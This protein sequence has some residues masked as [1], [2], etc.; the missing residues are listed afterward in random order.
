MN[1][2]INLF[3][4]ASLARASFT[5]MAA[6]PAPSILPPP[7]QVAAE[8]PADGSGIYR[9]SLGQAIN[10]AALIVLV[11]VKQGK[12][13][14]AVA[15]PTHFAPTWAEADVSGLTF[16]PSGFKGVLKVGFW[17][18]FS[19]YTNAAET[20]DGKPNPKFIAA[21]EAKPKQFVTITLDLAQTGR[22]GK[23]TW[24]GVWEGPS[25]FNNM[26]VANGGEI[27][28]LWQSARPDSS[29]VDR[30]EADLHMVCALVDSPMP[31][32]GNGNL[33]ATSPAVWLRLGL[34]RGKS[35]VVLGWAES[36]I[37]QQQSNPVAITIT[38]QNF[39]IE[40]GSIT[41]QVVAAYSDG[42]SEPFTLAVQGRALGGQLNGT[43]T[44]TQGAKTGTT[45]WIGL[46]HQ[47]STWRLPLEAAGPWTWQ[48]DLQ[49]DAA[50]NAA[51]Q[52]ESL[53]PVLPGEP[54]R[55]EFWTWRSLVRH[56][57]VSSIHPPSFDVK[58]TAG[59]TRYRY[60]LDQ[61]SEKKVA[62]ITFESDK[63]WR[64][65]TPAWKAMVPGNYQLTITPVDAQG[66]DLPGPMQLG[67][68]DPKTATA[69]AKVSPSIRIMK[70]P[71]FSGPYASLAGRDWNRTVLQA[72]RWLFAPIG[73]P[74]NRGQD[75]GST[76]QS[77]GEADTGAWITCCLQGR[78][79]IRAFSDSPVEF[80]DQE[81]F[82]LSLAESIQVH[83]QSV[84]QT[85]G[86]LRMY[87]GYTALNQLPGRAILDAWLQTGDPHWK[88]LAL[89]MGRGLAKIQKPNG[90]FGNSNSGTGGPGGFG[91][92]VG[93]PE[94]GAS[95]LLYL[96][97]RM[98]RDLKT[99]EFVAAETKAY[100][101]MMNQALP[102][103]FFPLYDH[104]SGSQAYPL[105][106]HAQ[107]ALFFS[108]YLL[109]LAP[110]ERKDVKLAEELAMWAEDHGINWARAAAGPQTG[111]ITP[112]LLRGDRGNDPAHN[113]MFAA[114]VFQE[115]SIATGK[116][117]WAAKAEALATA[118]IQ[119][120]DP[121]TG[122]C[123]YDLVPVHRHREFDEY[124]Y[125]NGSMGP[126][127]S[128]Q[129]LREYAQLKK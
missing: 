45:P 11:E 44:F 4:L 119:A 20:L 86:V 81:F 87:K 7:V 50:L 33:W 41:G 78:L 96:L 104:H 1:I 59:A 12:M 65:L 91:W 23:G 110:P 111:P 76:Y 47:A 21:Y 83:Q 102:R 117:L 94:F 108:R 114:V 58:E 36:P 13:A 62:P 5:L 66:K 25:S 8:R 128:L 53:L 15:L 3:L 101:W 89:A 75:P 48:H 40:N 71:A 93:N 35:T 24:K 115:L 52:E 28:S 57:S 125:H 6:D 90:A 106:Q 98:R 56:G 34:E 77:G 79:A 105:W 68:L 121:K 9:L 122:Y 30:Q 82:L 118:V 74:E 112:M 120:I 99:D 88:E 95:E 126:S 42:K 37:G 63:P 60:Q 100:G 32:L 80:G 84:T 19:R 92:N 10:K 124:S 38:K 18:L 31:I 61:E 103:R 17:P 85:P 43:V 107:S 69:A 109:E 14:G 49:P 127:A 113:N 22:E 70:R 26:S 39:M 54:G 55:L 64:P 72:A 123:N 73:H 29:Q 51:A 97:G 16:S 46:L 2:F 116:P 129:L 27:E 67:F